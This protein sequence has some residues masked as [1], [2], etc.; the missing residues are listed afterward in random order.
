VTG[1]ERLAG[2]LRELGVSHAFG[3]PGTQNATLF[4]ALAR[5]GVHPVLA[6]HEASAAFMANGFA[7]ISGLP[8]VVLAI[9]GPGFAFALPGLAEARLDSVPLLLITGSPPTSASGRPFLHQGL[10]QAAVAGPLVKAVLEV[11]SAEEVE[12]VVRRAHARALA[13]EPGPVVVQLGPAVAG[14]RTSDSVETGGDDLAP[15]PR[16]EARALELLLRRAARAERP[17][18][19]VGAGARSVSGPLQALA[20][21]WPAPVLTTLSGRGL[22]PEDHPL[23]LAFDADR[24]RLGDVNALLDRCDLI[25]AL[26]C[27][28][29]HNATAGFGLRLPAERLVQVNTDPM[30][31]GGNYP[32]DLQILGQ[33][34][35]VVGPLIDRIREGSS[36][37]W[38]A[39]EIAG[40]ARTIRDPDTA[41]P[42]EP[43]FGD[44]DPPTARAFF[45]SLGSALPRDAVVVT[46][47]GLHQVM[48]RRHLDVLAPGGLLV[49]A[50]LQSMGFGVPA[51]LGAA[52]GAPGRAVVAVVGDG[53]F[54]MTATDLLC[55]AREELPI[56]VI[57]FNDGQ[58]NL[59]RLQQV[60]DTGEARTVGLN[61]PDLAT[62]AEAFGVAYHRIGNDLEGALA[63]ARERTGPTLMEVRLGDSSE[64]RGLRLAS[65][66]KALARRTL[67]ARVLGRLKSLLG[68]S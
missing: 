6:T 14:G 17:A 2:T 48:T 24:G 64:I 35:D 47:S 23:A 10:D 56:P 19:F 52:L 21:L 16:P 11:E 22:V 54:L 59:I 13:G 63:R 30:A 50:D 46:D 66:G 8:G 20:E 61:T 45:A 40:A 34:A 15:S 51:A 55:M 53:G 37:R 28:L 18:L 39:P 26:G 12:S 33:V 41:W 3:L 44:R 29:S 31:L 49:P 60:R 7:R 5:S 42:P 1:A 43:R 57:V 4:P 25:L 36:S 62:L 58:L 65:A 68:R 9:P 27:K 32:A 67:G 38:E